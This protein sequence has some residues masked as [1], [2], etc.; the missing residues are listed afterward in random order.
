MPDEE[1]NPA[2]LSFKQ[3]LIKLLDKS[4]DN[5]EKQLSYISSGSIGVSMLIINSLFKDLSITVYKYTVITGWIVLALT[6][7]INLTS[8]LVTFNYHYR[9]ISE[10]DESSYDPKKAKSRNKKIANL[11]WLSAILLF[12]GILLIVIFISIN[13]L[14]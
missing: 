10:I 13:L 8:H 3:E 6:L 7:I 5:F 1:V 12:L 2:I 11:N 14:Q 9:T 4:Q